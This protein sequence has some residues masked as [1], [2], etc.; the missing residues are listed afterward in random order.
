MYPPT[1]LT[2]L[3]RSNIKSFNLFGVSCSSVC[4]YKTK[5]KDAPSR[6]DL[7]R[8][9][10]SKRAAHRERFRSNRRQT[11]Y[12][13]CARKYLLLAHWSRCVE[14]VHADVSF[15]IGAAKVSPSAPSPLFLSHLRP[16]AYISWRPK[17]SF[18]RFWT[19]QPSA[20]LLRVLTRRTCFWST[21]HAGAARS[22]DHGRT[23]SS[24]RIWRSRCK[25]QLTLR[26]LCRSRQRYSIFL[27]NFFF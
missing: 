20:H 11:R 6:E 17:E 10:L 7:M 5:W 19:S 27:F 21:E 23:K 8:R 15:R 16:S 13:C 14:D 3:L 9:S 2:L 1:S 22:H 12:L 18:E 4:T 25:Q 24:R 26:S